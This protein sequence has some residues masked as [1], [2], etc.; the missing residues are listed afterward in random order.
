MIIFFLHICWL[1]LVNFTLLFQSERKEGKQNTGVLGL[2]PRRI[3]GLK[4]YWG[5]GDVRSWGERF[6]FFFFKGPKT[7]AVINRALS[8]NSN[9]PLFCSCCDKEVF[10]LEKCNQPKIISLPYYGYTVTIRLLYWK[11]L[12]VTLDWKDVLRH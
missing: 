12:C 7:K 6:F 8:S 1:F 10:L 3:E 9:F 4:F 11:F 5:K 2:V